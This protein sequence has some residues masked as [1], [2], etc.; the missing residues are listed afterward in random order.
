MRVIISFLSDML[1]TQ[2]EA[3]VSAASPLFLSCTLPLHQLLISSSVNLEGESLA[4]WR[5]GVMDTTYHLAS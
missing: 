3:H 5:A 4:V 2:T 1:L